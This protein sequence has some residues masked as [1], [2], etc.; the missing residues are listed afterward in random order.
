MKFAKKYELCYNINDD[1]NSK[2]SE[3]LRRKAIGLKD[4]ISR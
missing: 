3:N 2:S 1:D 4:L